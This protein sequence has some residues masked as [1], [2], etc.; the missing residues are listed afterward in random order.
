MQTAKESIT[1]LAKLEPRVL[2]CGHGIP[3]TGDRIAGELRA[4]ADHFSVSTTW[5]K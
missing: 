1:A 4:F 2:A 5:I 3:M